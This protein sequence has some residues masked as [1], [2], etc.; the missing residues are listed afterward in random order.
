MP[1]ERSSQFFSNQCFF[2]VVAGI[3]AV[4]KDALSKTDAAGVRPIHLSFDIDGVDPSI[5]PGTGTKA[6]GG[7]TYREASVGHF[8]IVLS[9]CNFPSLTIYLQAHY[10]CEALHET[11]RLVSMD[12][13]E[14]NP[15]LDERDDT[16][17]GDDPNIS[18]DA[19]KTVRLG[20][21][22]VASALGKTILTD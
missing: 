21:E 7:L 10:I 19:T 13:V 22:L 3:A 9:I 4:I 5:A 15:D 16:H 2:H 8:G 14:I 6:R 12:L 17:H 11:G 18:K 1:N 20:I